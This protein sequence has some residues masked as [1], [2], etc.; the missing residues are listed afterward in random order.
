M[1]TIKFYLHLLGKKLV[2]AFE[3]LRLKAYLCAAGRWTIGYGNTFYEDGTIVRKGD[4]VTK[5][6]AVV[7]FDLIINKFGN[8]VKALTIDKGIELN[9]YQFSACVSIT[10]NIG[11]GAFGRS[12]IY[13]ALLAGDFEIASNSFMKFNKA[14]NK[15]TGKLRVLRGLTRR[16]KREIELFN[17]AWIAE[18]TMTEIESIKIKP[19]DLFKIQVDKMYTI[20]NRKYIIQVD[21]DEA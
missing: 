14:R 17:K 19:I 3:G 1:K 8:R 5:A 7:L 11:V 10:Y 4:K 20:N 6:R 13:R 12:S 21:E 15:K 9:P 18:P 16:R 2:M